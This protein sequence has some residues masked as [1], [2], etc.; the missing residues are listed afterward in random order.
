MKKNKSNQLVLAGLFAALTAVGAFL[1]IPF[2][3]VP[4]TLQSLFT[5][6]AGVLLVPQYA[7]LSQVT[8]LVIGLTGLPVFANGGGLGY[9]MQPTFGY[10]LS[11]PIAAFVVSSMIE[12]SPKTK[13]VFKIFVASLTGLLL[14]LFLGSVW[15]YFSL[16]FTINSSLAFFPTVKSGALV[17]L[18]G[19]LVKALFV[20]FVAHYLDKRL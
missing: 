12:N 11:L 10:L 19:T 7:L 20:T 16:K 1:K 8:Y 18:P 9:V 4:L 15:L 5:V 17:F 3:V 6:L 13:S 2:P 14:I